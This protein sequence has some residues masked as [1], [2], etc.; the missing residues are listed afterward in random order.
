MFVTSEDLARAKL[1][2]IL[3]DSVRGAELMARFAFELL[4]AAAMDDEKHQTGQ[5]DD[6]REDW[7]EDLGGEA[8]FN[9]LDGGRHGFDAL[10]LRQSFHTEGKIDLHFAGFRHDHFLEI[11]R[12]ALVPCFEFVRAGGDVG[13]AKAT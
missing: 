11:G 9:F 3:E 13:D 1:E 6:Q 12:D 4:N 10:V 8:E 2:R 5:Q 7:N